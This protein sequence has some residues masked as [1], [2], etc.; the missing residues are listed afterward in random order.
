M[1]SPA[2]YLIEHI[3]KALAEEHPHQMGFTIHVDTDEIR[4]RGPIDSESDR[5]VILEVVE[6][7]AEGRRVLDDLECTEAE[8]SVRTERLR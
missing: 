3:R 6:R 1:H 4:I 7:H 8:P 5:A 2:E